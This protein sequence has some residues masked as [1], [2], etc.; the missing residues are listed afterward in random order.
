MVL[1]HILQRAV[2]PGPTQVYPELWTAYGIMFLACLVPVGI[3]RWVLRSASRS[4]R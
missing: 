3:G 1:G 2:E 4:R